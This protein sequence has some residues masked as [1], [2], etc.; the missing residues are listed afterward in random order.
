[1]EKL[2]ILKIKSIPYGQRFTVKEG[3]GVKEY[4]CLSKYKE[5]YYDGGI[6]CYTCIDNCH[7]ICEKIKWFKG[8]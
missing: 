8:E 1:M 4:D 3:D 2:K 6:K 5:T 7:T